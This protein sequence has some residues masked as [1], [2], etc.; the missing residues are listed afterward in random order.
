MHGAVNPLGADTPDTNGDE[1]IDEFLQALATY[2]PACRGR[3]LSR[4]V[5]MDKPG[6]LA[7][8]NALYD[9]VSCLDDGGGGDGSFLRLVPPA[10]LGLPEAPDLR[11]SGP[12]GW[13]GSRAIR[14]RR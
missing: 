12:L 1:E 7:W 11:L 10:V 2:L 5:I 14:G 3:I 13:R 4:T 9:H 6:V 8:L